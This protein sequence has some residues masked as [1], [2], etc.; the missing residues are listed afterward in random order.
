MGGVETSPM[1]RLSLH[2]S[3]GAEKVVPGWHGQAPHVRADV[4]FVGCRWVSGSNERFPL[5]REN[6]IPTLYNKKT[7]SYHLKKRIQEKCNDD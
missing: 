7:V 6:F 3:R 4:E 2:G 5:F 1:G